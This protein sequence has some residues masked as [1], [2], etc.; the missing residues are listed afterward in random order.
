VPD[1]EAVSAVWEIRNGKDSMSICDCVKRMIEDLNV[2]HHEGVLVTGN[3]H[4]ARFLHDFLN[5]F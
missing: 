5:A 4:E 3:G 1:G 2:A